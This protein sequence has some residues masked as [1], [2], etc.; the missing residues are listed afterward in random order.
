MYID[1]ASIKGFYIPFWFYCFCFQWSQS[2]HLNP[3]PSTEWPISRERSWPF[4]VPILRLQDPYVKKQLWVATASPHKWQHSQIIPGFFLANRIL[5]CPKTRC[6][7]SPMNC[8]F[9][10]PR[11]SND[12]TTFIKKEKIENISVETSEIS[13]KHINHLFIYRG[14]PRKQLLSD[15]RASFNIVTSGPLGPLRGPVVK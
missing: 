13:V 10:V 1:F 2:Q 6:L 15:C 14:P 7:L 5:R 12:G 4:L 3:I 8:L 9:P 11:R